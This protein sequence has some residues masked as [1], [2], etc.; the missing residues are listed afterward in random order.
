MYYGGFRLLRSLQI[1]RP[2]TQ[3]G[4]SALGV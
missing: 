2:S 3:H 4:L 1:I